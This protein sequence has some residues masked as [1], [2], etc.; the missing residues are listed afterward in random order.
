MAGNC[1]L[2]SLIWNEIHCFLL[3][4]SG[5]LGRPRCTPSPGCG[6][7]GP[8]KGHQGACDPELGPRMLA[9]FG[10]SGMERLGV[11][12]SIPALLQGETEASKGE[13][14]NSESQGRSKQRRSGKQ[15]SW[16][17]G[18]QVSLLLQGTLSLA[19]GGGGA[20][21]WGG[22]SRIWLEVA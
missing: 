18:F 14:T 6:L 21:W 20:A 1:A 12:V 17:S 19:A 11:I 16:F 22:G 4:G 7:S 8:T 15:G 9:T 10:A 13:G 3:G 5:A 2:S